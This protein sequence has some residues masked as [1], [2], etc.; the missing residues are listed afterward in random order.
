M[1]RRVL[2]VAALVPMLASSAAAQQET[3]EAVVG[4]I[5]TALK[6][7]DFGRMTGLM[8][9][10]ALHQMRTM[11][12]PILAAEGA[13]L[14]SARKLLFGF[15]TRAEATAASDSAI[16]AG[17]M[18]FG[19]GQQPAVAEAMRSSSYKIIGTVREG[20]DTAHVV[21]RISM[22]IEGIHVSQVDVTSLMRS[23]TTWRAM[24]KGDLSDMA[25]KLR[26]AL[27]GGQQ[28]Q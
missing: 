17:L 5:I 21:A 4:Q 7:G 10:T 26:A 9:P 6:G 16:M 28:N 13:E 25:A 19:F 20:P 1:I 12:D 2:T 14:D 3:P 18:R 24:L 22:N 27:L 23:G 15:R 11:L 8:H